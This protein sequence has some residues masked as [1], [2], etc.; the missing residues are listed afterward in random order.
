MLARKKTWKNDKNVEKITI[1]LITFFIEL[2]SKTGLVILKGEEFAYSM[3][4]FP[5]FE[6]IYSKS[7]NATKFVGRSESGE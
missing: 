4:F 1:L 5:G 7:Y 3:V 6:S 2:Q